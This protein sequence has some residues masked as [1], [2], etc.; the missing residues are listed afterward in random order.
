VER[1]EETPVIPL[2]VARI[3]ATTAEV[4]DFVEQYC[5]YFTADVVFVPTE[6]LQPPGRRVRFVFALAGGVELI[7][8]EGIVLRMRRD[9]GDPLRPPG[10]E[11]RY[12]VLDEASQELVDRMLAVRSG[13]VRLKRPQ[14]PPYV[15]L[16]V[17]TEAEPA[18]PPPFADVP[19]GVLSADIDLAFRRLLQPAPAPPPVLRPV[20]ALGPPTER[21]FLHR[22]ERPAHPQP[23]RPSLAALSLL[24]ALAGL[25]AS[26]ALWPG[27]DGVRFFGFPATRKTT[28]RAGFGVGGGGAEPETPPEPVRKPRRP[29]PAQ[30]FI[31]SKPRGAWVH[32]DGVLAGR[33]PVVATVAEGPHEVRIERA[34]YLPEQTTVFAPGHV[35]VDL[36]RAR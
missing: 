27:G 36:R 29:L 5:R 35:N 21:V 28:V 19:L 3:V 17:E 10:M 26:M 6:G 7:T 2:I 12:H 34:R 23:R 14:P 30:L 32:V 9:S 24:A 11:L 16:H 4:D 1:D 15:S 13:S 20:P 18:P 8:G 31:A 33:T 22:R 25:G